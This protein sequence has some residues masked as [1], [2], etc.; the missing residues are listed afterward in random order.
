M[1]FLE[2][3]IEVLRHEPEPLHFAEIAKRAVQ[4]NLL[5]HVGRD[6][7]AAMRTCLNSAVRGEQAILTRNKPG[8]YALTPGIAL[9]PP[10]AAP[11]VPEPVVAPVKVAPPVVQKPNDVE[12]K[13]ENVEAK[14]RNAVAP[15]APVAPA[16]PAP[17]SPAS[18][19]PASASLEAEAEGEEEGEPEG[20]AEEGGGEE[21]G[22]SEGG[23]RKR[24][25]SRFGV[26][27]EAPPPQL[28]AVKPSRRGADTSRRSEVLQKV[29]QLEFEAPRSAGLSGVTDVAL[30]MANAMSRLA[31]ERPELRGEFESLQRGTAPVAQAPAVHEGRQGQYGRKGQA[32]PQRE[33][34]RERERHAQGNGGGPNSGNG[35]GGN[36][37]GGG[38]NNF[39]NSAGGNNFGNSAG[40]SNAGGNSSG[41]NAGANNFGG[42]A[43]ANN[44][45]GAQDEDDRGGRRRR[46]RRR[47]GRR[48]DWN[49]EGGGDARGGAEAQA[50]GL[51]QQVAQVLGE[52]GARSLH[53]RQIAENLANQ[54]VLGGEISEIE[55]AVTAA[56]LLDIR[57]LG[58][59]SRFVARGDAR[60]QLQAARLPGP[61]AVSEQALRTAIAA[62]EDET[63]AQ[64]V[65]W[66]QS[67]GPRALE[68]IVRMYLER[69]GFGLIATLPPTRGVGKL[70]VS[71]PESE[72]E[73]GRLLALVL[74]R[75]TT[76]DATAWAGDGERN[77]CGGYLVFAMGEPP[78]L[79]GE[80]RII[81]AHELARW[82][83]TQGIGVSTMTI[84]VTVLDPTVIESISGLDT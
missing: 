77:A 76:V 83:R 18:A 13:A 16:S 29:Q 14:T 21:A 30:V 69:E 81:Q 24:R 27:G 55:R 39:G 33:R 60:Y 58:R 22:R 49:G 56:V 20:D 61:A 63:T 8:Y 12:V 73:D 31:E 53:I 48:V 66:L 72:D 4:R 28:V 74:P 40:T 38:G 7:E 23:R 54:N 1:T 42:N 70:V 11:A 50:Q 68:A 34:E 9:P 80:V 35:F 43:G 46:R 57:K 51:L 59:A 52:A 3:A 15:A 47:R 65:Q 10:P 25:R 37:A 36:N 17:A 78:D 44:F 84:E 75:K 6:P 2:A 64:I 26:R 32:P 67:L 62:V 71:D 19:S 82:L 41:A 45:A 79:A 5:S